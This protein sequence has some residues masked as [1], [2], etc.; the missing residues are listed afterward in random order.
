MRVAFT[1]LVG[2]END[3]GSVGGER[4]VCG[5]AEVVGRERLRLARPH[6]NQ[7]EVR[8]GPPLRVRA[9]SES[10]ERATPTPSAVVPRASRPCVGRYAEAVGPPPS[11]VS[12][13]RIHLPSESAPIARPVEPAQ[14]LRLGLSLAEGERARAIVIFRHEHARPAT[15]RRAGVP[16]I[17]RMS[18]SLPDVVTA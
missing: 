11:P 14:V 1:A 17:V 3:L 12:S 18:R 16:C 10:G 6:W 13:K 5:P 8:G 7:N 4:P 9:H 15:S 2:L